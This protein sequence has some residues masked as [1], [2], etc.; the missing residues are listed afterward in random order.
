MRAATATLTFVLVLLAPALALAQAGPVTTLAPDAEGRW[1]DFE[2]TPY[3]Q[4]RFPITIDGHAAR[5]VLDTGLSDTI[6]T[7]RFARAAGLSAV[8]RQRAIAIG[9][10]VEVGWAPI[11]TLAFAGLTRAGGR[12]GIAEPKGEE[13]LGADV[14]IGADILSC[15]ALDI[16]YDAHRFRLLASGR[17]PFT[18]SS[19]P[20]RRRAG[21]VY[22]TEVT[23]AG[24]RLR[25]I[26]VDTGDG[27]ALTLSRSAWLSTGYSTAQR[28]TTLGWGMGGPVV[29][30]TLVLPAFSLAATPPVE[31]EVRIEEDSGF[32]GAIGVAG[33]LGTG[34]LLRYRV[35]LDPGAG[36]MVLQRGKAPAAVPRSTTGLLLEFTGTALRVVH[37]MRGSPAAAA[38]WKAGEQI[39]TADGE[40]VA[41][42]VKRVGVV[43]W[44]V[45]VPGR[46]V[47]LGLCNGPERSLTLARFY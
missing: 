47:R 25:P 30:D 22:Q 38:G 1:V 4:I 14:L 7:A 20:L 5:A 28:T 13:R 16:D 10:G 45:G 36:R 2:L 12:V 23:V 33:R 17:M 34:M 21:G 9:G 15:C 8:R 26:V 46:V 43:E 41:E 19:V 18:G 27:G 11:R 40:A 24:K 44:S 37:V 6:V 39:C 29:T 35:L 42:Q 31:A 32:S 3:N